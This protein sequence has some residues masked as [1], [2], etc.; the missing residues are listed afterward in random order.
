M[1]G[2]LNFSSIVTQE[3]FSLFTGRISRK[4]S[5]ISS[6]IISSQS[7]NLCKYKGYSVF[8]EVNS[9]KRLYKTVGREF[10]AVHYES[11][12]CQVIGAGNLT[13]TSLY[14]I[15]KYEILLV[16]FHLK[17]VGKLHKH[18]KRIILLLCFAT[19]VFWRL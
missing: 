14:N 1:Y 15:A 12:K 2:E 3:I 17:E 10:N 6:K 8:P 7:E 4:I 16:C 18:P 11:S 13:T 19:L 5:N 9:G